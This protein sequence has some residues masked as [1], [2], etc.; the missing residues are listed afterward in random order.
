MDKQVLK[1]AVLDFAKKK[2]EPFTTAEAYD[3]I[4]CAESV[5]DVSEAIRSLYT[6][7]DKLIARKRID[8]VRFSYVLAEFSHGFEGYEI[9]AQKSDGLKKNS[10]NQVAAAANILVNPTG[11][12]PIQQKPDGFLDTAKQIVHGDRERIY[13]DTGKNLRRIASYWSIH[14]GIDI[15][16]YD[17]CIMMMLLKMA[18]LGNDPEHVDSW[19]DIA[20]YVALKDKIREGK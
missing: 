19:V 17:V 4:D 11:N 3:A 10:D 18:R 20:D 8:N 5:K 2:R 1:Q 6:S 14:L 15:T 9:D 13:S 12:K 7:A 16:Q